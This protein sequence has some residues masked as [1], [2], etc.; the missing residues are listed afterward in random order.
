MTFTWFIITGSGRE[1]L[2]NSPDSELLQLAQLQQDE[3]HRRLCQ[4]ENERERG[5]SEHHPQQAQ[6]H[7]ASSDTKHHRMNCGTVVVIQYDPK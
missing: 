5:R 7:Q 1:P 3:H 2:G 4:S 6:H